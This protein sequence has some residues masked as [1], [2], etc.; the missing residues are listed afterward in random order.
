MILLLSLEK[1]LYDTNV[2]DKRDATVCM[3]SFNPKLLYVTNV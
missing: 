1:S 3:L 2:Y